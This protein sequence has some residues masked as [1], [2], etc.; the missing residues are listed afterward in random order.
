MKK[1]L[2]LLLAIIMATGISV[3]VFAGEYDENEKYV[4]EQISGK[5]FPV[6]IE[7]RYIN[8]LENY[9]CR[10]DV[11]LD[12]TD[13]QDFVMYLEKALLE[14]R[15]ISNKASFDEKSSVYQNF[16]KAGSLIG[17]LVE[18]DSAVNSFYAID[19]FGYIIID[20]QNIIKNTGKVADDDETGETGNWNI[21][22][23]ILFACVVIMC[24]LGVLTNLR[25]W[26]RKMRRHTNYEEEDEEEDELEVANRK[27]RRARLQT[28]SYKS[29]KQVLRYFYI[30]IIM[31]LIVVAIAFAFGNMYRDIIES[32]STNFI[33]TQPVYNHDKEGFTIAKTDKKQQGKTIDLNQVVYP[34]YGEQY[35]KLECSRLK[36][37]APVYF[38]DGGMLLE[39]GAGS[40]A[41]SMIPGMGRT[42]LIG[43]HDT[44][45]FLGLEKV[46]KGDVFTFSTEYGIYDYKVTDFKVYDENSYDKAY[47][48][49]ADKEKLVLYTCYPFG[50]L[51]G[52]KTQRM[53]VYLD[54][55]AGPDIKY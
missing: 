16:Q 18:Y 2:L 40:Y 14:K 10:D 23:E 22:I 25:R 39:S 41:G 3:N 44:T 11:Q 21:S 48:L 38:G 19:E 55:T 42:I 45:Y 34:K 6:E 47:D 35:G 24:I 7:A 30:P 1:I 27:T 20:S 36:I 54:K 46:K 28:F 29:I 31:G 51:N 33:N 49:R 5:K 15:Q 43:A 50:T 17:L 12:K 4:I 9:F 26:N 37:N 32:V 13:A 53:F 52:T 8:Q